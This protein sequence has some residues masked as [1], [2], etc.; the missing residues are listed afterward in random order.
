[1]CRENGQPPSKPPD[2]DGLAS[3]IKNDPT[4]MT[5]KMNL[6][7]YLTT[8]IAASVL[9]TAAAAQAVSVNLGNIM[10]LGDSITAGYIPGGCIPGGYR[11][12]LYTNL[13]AANCA[14]HFVGSQTVYSSGTLD[15]T[16]QNHHEGHDAY[17][18]QQIIDGVKNSNWLDVNPDIILLHIGANDILTSTTTAASERFDTLL[19]EIVARKPNARIIVAKI[20]GGSTVTND[21]RAAAYDSGIVDYNAAIE[22]KVKHHAEDLGQRV[23][24][25]DM[26][27]L[28]NIS[29]QTDTQGRPLF[30]DI[31]HPT[32]IGYNLMGDAWAGAIRSVSIPEPGVVTLA[33]TGVA[34]LLAHAWSRRKRQTPDAP[35]GGGPT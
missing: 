19:G 5:N 10:P 13:T 4:T 6:R 29:H 26:Y 11:Q 7:F 1:M 22:L 34:S 31:S 21:S 28:M 35:I 32:Q 16:D 17:S 18:I 20:I 8:L 14:F 2:K 25:I 12:E 33:A 9:A 15:A 24:L 23:S 3:Q 30:T 27:S